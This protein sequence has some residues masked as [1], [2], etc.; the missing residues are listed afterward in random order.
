[1]VF[2]LSYNLVYRSKNV[3]DMWY[4]C[5]IILVYLW[6]CYSRWGMI[7]T[8]KIKMISMW[9]KGF[10]FLSYFLWHF[11]SRKIIE[12]WLFPSLQMHYGKD[13]VIGTNRN[14]VFNCCELRM[15]FC[16]L[17]LLCNCCILR[18]EGISLETEIADP[19]FGLV[20]N[21]TERI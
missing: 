2:L 21:L 4:I 1:M 13:S 14:S 20:V 12:I 3:I 16:W 11:M 5:Y 10:C 6:I 7:K 17:V 15:Q 19:K 8:F 9:K 18:R